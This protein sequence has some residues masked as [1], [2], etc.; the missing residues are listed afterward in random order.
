[1][2]YEFIE[3][4]DA[5][6][7][8]AMKA[9]CDFFASYPITPASSILHYMN[10][11]VPEV[12]G[13]VIQAEDEI[14][15]MGF[16]IGAAMAGRKVLTATSGPG[17]SLYSENIGLA[18]MGETPMV[19]VNV[20]RQGPATGSATEGAE[21]DIQFVRWVTS[22]GLPIIALSPANVGEAYYLTYIAFNFAEKYRTP[23]FIMSS[24]DI[25][26]TKETVDI[27][28]IELPPRIERNR[29][30]GKKDDYLPHWFENPED[31][32]PIADFG[33]D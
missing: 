5:I 26:V 4:N 1:M 7:R 17:L 25:G 28:S 2:G 21:G 33:G 22:G 24:K 20:Q 11:F 16:C 9:G 19:I 31:V 23:V 8:G 32:P 12:G 15:S 29:L 10:Y 27:D 30:N 6:A 3:G 18:I 13:I 14:A